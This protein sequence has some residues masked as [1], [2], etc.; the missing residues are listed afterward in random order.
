MSKSKI[1][2]TDRTWNPVTGCTKVSAGC[3]NCYA[4]RMAKRLAGRAGYPKDNP[5]M[6]VLHSAEKISQPLKW[7]KQSRIFVC[8]M[9]DLFHESLPFWMIDE[10]MDTCMMADWHTYLFLTKRP[11]QAYKYFESTSNR[12]EN[13]QKLNAM[14]G[15]TAENQ[16]QFDIRWSIASQIPASMLWVS[17]EPLLGPIDFSKHERK[18]DWFVVGGESGP[19]ARPMHPDWAR[20]LRDQCQAAGVPFL[21]KQWGEFAPYDYDPRNPGRTLFNKPHM[22]K[23]GKKKAGR[24]LDGKLWDEYPEDSTL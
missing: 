2:W 17:G 4:E 14:L 16:E 12:M 23:V 6:P 24:L 9:G 15:V 7:K 22:F 3:D 1:E 11:E 5:F 21:F 13:F 18:P 20:T 8:S 10:V 19:G